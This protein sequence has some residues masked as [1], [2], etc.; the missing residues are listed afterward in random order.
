[1]Y[2]YTIYHVSKGK[3]DDQ[4]NPYYVWTQLDSSQ[5]K[6]PL[7]PQLQNEV[8]M[9]SPIYH[10]PCTPCTTLCTPYT[11]CTPRI[12]HRTPCS[13][14]IDM[15]IPH[16]SVLLH[17]LHTHPPTPHATPH[18][19]PH[20]HHT[21]HATPHTPHATPHTPHATPHTSHPT[22]HTPHATPQYPW[23]P[24]FMEYAHGS[25][26]FTFPFAEQLFIGGIGQGAAMH[27][28]GNSW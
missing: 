25:W 24:S 18:P 2:L 21:P 3:A 4:G 8:N 26:N 11:P 20:P 23:K 1:M 9:T 6:D 5:S 19:H 7:I 16:I 12:P 14:Y 10:V 15:L 22:P 28:H 17:K 13:Y 27:W